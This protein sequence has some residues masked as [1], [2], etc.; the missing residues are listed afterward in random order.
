MEILVLNN[1]AIG[2]T[3]LGKSVFAA[4][5]FKKG[6]VITPFTG[7][8]IHKSKIPKSYR[9][10]RDRYMQIDKEYYLGPSGEIDDLINHSCSPNAGIKFTKAGILLV[11][12]TDIET[13]EEITW[14]YSTTMFDNSWKMKCD[15][16]KPEC[17][18][19]IGDFMLLD[20]K[21]QEK[22]LKLGVLPQYAKDYMMSSLYSV[23]TEGIRRLLKHERKAK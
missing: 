8:R 21:T 19:I 4:R 23:Y 13:G 22:Y 6:D 11:A 12:I 2:E 9:G 15:C 14:D 17:R 20:R 16:R 5:S 18:K 10:E 1:F 7:E 3:H